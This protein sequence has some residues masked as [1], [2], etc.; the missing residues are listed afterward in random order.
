MSNK[1]IN[2][3]TV[4]PTT[5]YIDFPYLKEDATDIFIHNYAAFMDRINKVEDD[6]PKQWL[7]AAN[8]D[9]VDIKLT[10]TDIRDWHYSH[11]EVRS[12]AQNSAFNI[13]DATKRINYKFGETE[14]YFMHEASSTDAKGMIIRDEHLGF[15]FDLGKPVEFYPDEYILFARRM[16]KPYKVGD[17]AYTTNRTIP[18]YAR[19]R[20]I[21]AG[22]TANLPFVI[23]RFNL[24]V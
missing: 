5:G 16:N 23:R 2:S 14:V 8:S 11:T 3:P 4:N 10:K 20:C 24:T 7:I 21:Q 19:L 22:T 1:N 17:I 13:V 9:G 6:R 18:S 12:A 15:S